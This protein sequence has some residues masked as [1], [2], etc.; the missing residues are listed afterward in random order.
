MP[1][2]PDWITPVTDALILLPLLIAIVRAA[3]LRSFAKMSA[4]DFVVTVATGSVVAATVLNHDTPWWQGAV[5]L[6]GLFLV[7]IL[8]G[9][10]RARFP[11]IQRLIDNEPLVLLRDGT[12]DDDALRHARISRDDLRQKLRAA[13]CASY[14]DAAMVVF[15]TTGDVTVMQK[16][17]EPDLVAEVRGAP[18]AW[19]G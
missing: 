7:Q 15:E 16:A 19:G 9:A 1:D 17:P 8:I 4:H 5:A 11:A 3:G 18:T 6:T 2:I 13:G 14:A 10:L 12:P